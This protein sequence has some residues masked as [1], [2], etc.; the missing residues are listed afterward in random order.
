VT[1]EE[2]ED[3]F[4]FRPEHRGWLAMHLRPV[5][6]FLGGAFMTV[7][8]LGYARFAAPFKTEFVEAPMPLAKLPASFEGFRILHLSDFHTGDVPARYLR[9]VIARCNQMPYDL[10]VF[11]GDFVSHSL[12]HVQE[13]A[14]LLGE[15]RR[16]VAVVF[17]NH[18]YSTSIETWSSSE[19]AEALTEA[20]Q[21]HG[22]E[23]LRNR[24]MTIRRGEGQI[25]IVGLEDFWSGKFS[26]ETAFAGL[27]KNAAIIALSHNADSVFTL[28]QS[29][30]DWVLAGHTHGGQIRIPVLGP[31]VLP[32]R[33]KQFDMGLF[34]VRGTKLYVS[35]GV[36]CR[37]PVRF[38]CRPEV[39]TFVLT[40][41]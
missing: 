32:V 1:Q 37:V 39:T 18:D 6:N 30:A 12:K 15:L 17:G 5:A 34:D 40:R 41:G 20:L 16:P 14:D 36:G 31:M 28:R 19:V 25:Q 2:I 9:K 4:E 22:I 10:A 27:D 38:R 21:S 13:A 11:T 7:A 3:A 35:R 23:V 24:A 33:F 29:G 26:A 8:T